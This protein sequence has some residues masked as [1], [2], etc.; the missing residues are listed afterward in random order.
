M[1]QF[2]NSTDAPSRLDMVL[3]FVGADAQHIEPRQC[4]KPLFETETIRTAVRISAI[5]RVTTAQLQA[6]GSDACSRDL[7]RP[8]KM[9]GMQRVSAVGFLVSGRSTMQDH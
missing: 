9:T 6:C 5:L 2:T 7:E 4:G 1:Q 8:V 3:T